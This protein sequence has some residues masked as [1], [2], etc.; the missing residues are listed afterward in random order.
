M[1]Q[2]SP[3]TKV[4]GVEPETCTPFSSSIMKGELISSEK[5]SKFCNGSSVKR[6]G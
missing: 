3:N 2:V 4:I 5:V 1:K 6:I